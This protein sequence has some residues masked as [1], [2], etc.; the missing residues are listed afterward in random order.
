MG[1]LWFAQRNETKRNQILRGHLKNS[2]KLKIASSF[3]SCMFGGILLK[4]DVFYAILIF[5]SPTKTLGRNYRSCCVAQNTVTLYANCT[6]CNATQQDFKSR[7]FLPMDCKTAVCS[8][9]IIKVSTGGD[10]TD[11]QWSSL[12]KETR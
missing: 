3:I 12:I 10:I 5:T 4:T 6:L 9:T 8:E 2:K 1:L 7:S 11:D